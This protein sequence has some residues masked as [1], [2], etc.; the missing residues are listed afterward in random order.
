MPVPVPDFDRVQPPAG[1]ASNANIVE[2]DAAYDA[3]IPTYS[4]FLESPVHGSPLCGT[5]PHVK[6]P[7]DTSLKDPHACGQDH[8]AHATPTSPSNDL[9]GG[10][11]EE[12][13]D[14]GG[15]PIISSGV[16]EEGSLET[17]LRVERQCSR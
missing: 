2:A 13:R 6:D 10:R 17:A 12:H 9:G 7:G 11:S 8:V 3:S 5:A 1:S 15:L 14:C 4:C 16:A